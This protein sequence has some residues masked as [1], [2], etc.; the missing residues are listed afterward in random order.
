M[1]IDQATRIVQDSYPRI[2]LACHTRHDRSG[3]SQHGLSRR[4]SQVLQHLDVDPPYRS[5]G[6]ARHLGI[7]A[8][9]LSAKIDR[10]EALGLVRRRAYEGDRRQTELLLTA[11]GRK[12]V[13]TASVLEPDRVTALLE[14]L[15][16]QE[17]ATAVAGLEI[18]GR[19]ATDFM[20]ESG[21]ASEGA[22]R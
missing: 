18:L 16:P 21:A 7:G 2:Y 6:L 14:R 22:A 12:R 1:N 10:L 13:R 5:G 11:E 20:D 8:P 3:T 15:T 17:M 19:V 4:E 9:A